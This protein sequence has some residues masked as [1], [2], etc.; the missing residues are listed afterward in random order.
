MVQGLT[1]HGSEK[2]GHNGE[3]GM[4]SDRQA[5]SPSLLLNAQSSTKSKAEINK[6]LDS[7]IVSEEG[8]VPG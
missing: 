4:N 6:A 5:D 1:F 3:M 2:A 7:V 8:G